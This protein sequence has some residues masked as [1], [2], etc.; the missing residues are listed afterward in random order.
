M[1][2]QAEIESLSVLDA[3]GRRIHSRDPVNAEAPDAAFGRL[4]TPAEERFLRCHFAMPRLGDSHAVVMAGA[5]IT[6]RVVPARRLGRVPA[7]TKTVVTE[8]AGN[9]RATIET[10]VSGE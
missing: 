4:I 8:G 7:V 6:P 1:R 10:P 9:G 3:E 2:V 5:V